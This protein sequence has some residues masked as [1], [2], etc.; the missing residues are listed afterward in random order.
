[1]YL[2][3]AIHVAVINGC[4]QSNE[5]L[6]ATL[7]IMAVCA[8]GARPVRFFLGRHQ[9]FSLSV[10]DADIFALLK[11]QLKDITVHFFPSV[12][13]LHKQKE[14]ITQVTKKQIVIMIS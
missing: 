10:T 4:A 3:F 13:R 2:G 12:C 9:Y 11:L 5:I 1:L 6:L 7:H 14:I 8:C